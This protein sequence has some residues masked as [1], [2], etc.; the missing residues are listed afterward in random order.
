MYEER[1]KKVKKVCKES[2]LGEIERKESMRMRKGGRTN[3]L[4][5]SSFM[6]SRRL[7]LEPV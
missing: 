1:K 6:P 2:V 4:T 3:G 7:V 5:V